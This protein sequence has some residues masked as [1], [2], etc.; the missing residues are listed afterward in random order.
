MAAEALK[1]VVEEIPQVK[2]R[3]VG[4]NQDKDNQHR[5][6]IESICLRDNTF[7]YIEFLGQLSWMELSDLYYN[8]GAY[9][10]PTICMESFGLNWAEAM[11]TGCPVVASDIGSVS[12]LVA[13]KGILVPPRDAKELAKAVTRLLKDKDY[14]FELKRSG[15]HYARKSF[16]IGRAVDELIEVY[17]T[18]TKS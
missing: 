3:F 12:E 5:K 10:C 15:Q 18:L 7:S 8:A 13:D 14:A 6:R 4:G 16:D 11:A 17:D 9:I 1:Y 2:L